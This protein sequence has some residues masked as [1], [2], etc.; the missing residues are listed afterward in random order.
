MRVAA[1]HGQTWVTYGPLTSD[2]PDS[3]ADHG[4]A[5]RAWFAGVAEQVERL[6]AACHAVGRDP[7]TLR[8]MALAGLDLAHECGADDVEG[9]GLARQDPAALEPTEH[10]RADA[11]RVACAVEGVVVHEHQ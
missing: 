8:R 2:A 10:E 4:A 11:L 1:E 3:G 9:R 7:A 6:D 5:A